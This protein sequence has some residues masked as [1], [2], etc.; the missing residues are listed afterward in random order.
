MFPGKPDGSAA[1]GY[2]NRISGLPR[3]A[4]TVRRVRDEPLPT[5]KGLSLFG[6]EERRIVEQLR[7]QRF[8]ATITT[9]PAAS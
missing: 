7:A 3:A 4:A 2:R 9:P 1:R 6:E 8:L 5:G